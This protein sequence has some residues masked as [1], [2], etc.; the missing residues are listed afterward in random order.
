MRR[1]LVPCFWARHRKFT[2]GAEEQTTRSPRVADRSLCLLPID[3]TGRQRSAMYSVV[4]FNQQQQHNNNEL[5]Q[6]STI[7]L[8]CAVSIYMKHHCFDVSAQPTNE[9]FSL[10]HSSSL[11]RQ[12]KNI[13]HVSHVAE[14]YCQA[15]YSTDKVDIEDR[16]HRYEMTSPAVFCV[17]RG[18]CYVVLNHSLQGV[19]VRSAFNSYVSRVNLNRICTA[20]GGTRDCD[21]YMG[22]MGQA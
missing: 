16:R 2:G 8:M 15:Y 9:N 20:V 7:A 4:A 22:A 1:Q 18:R 10:R 11:F 12:Q 13:S 5:Q 17:R 3:V 6:L 14:Q 21:R 19:Q